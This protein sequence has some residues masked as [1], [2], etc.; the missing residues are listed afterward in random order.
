MISEKKK[1]EHESYGMLSFTN[2][3]CNK[4]INLFGSSIKCS[5]YIT[6]KV[7][8][9][10]DNR[11]LSE[12]WYYPKKC[13]MEVQLS[14][15]QFAEA[16]TNTNTV[17]VPCTLTRIMGQR[18]ETPPENENMM[19]LQ[20]ELDDHINELSERIDK[21]TE[22]SNI[23]KNQKG[24]LKVGEKN[25]LINGIDSVAQQLKSNIPFLGKQVARQ[26]NRTVHQSKCEVDSFIS[27]LTNKLG[28]KALKDKFSMNKTIEIDYNGG[29]E[30][31][32]RDI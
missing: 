19:D 11:G 20:D 4:G 10:E 30:D 28:I 24:G 13:I 17:G 5:N 27:G 3:T 14:P 22:Y 2:T 29:D 9:A 32:H 18:M 1:K 12:N 7:H 16:I 26:M 15:A 6:M 31:D 23:L 21:L 8:T 25:A